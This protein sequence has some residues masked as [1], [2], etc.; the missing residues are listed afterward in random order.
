M[1]AKRKRIQQLRNAEAYLITEKIIAS[2]GTKR[3]IKGAED[4]KPAI[5][6]FKRK[7]S[8]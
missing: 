2:K 3:K 8:K 6:K 7:R 4:G 5:Y 1:E